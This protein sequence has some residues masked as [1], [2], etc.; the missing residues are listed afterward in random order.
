MGKL[1][2]VP[3]GDPRIHR[4]LGDHERSVSQPQ[5]TVKVPDVV[6]RAAKVQSERTSGKGDLD[7]QV[8]RWLGSIIPDDERE[9]YHRPAVEGA[10][11][12]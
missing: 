8:F 4:P 3:A 12:G 6:V 9:I 1:T 5:V 10:L 2:G 7:A 11:Y